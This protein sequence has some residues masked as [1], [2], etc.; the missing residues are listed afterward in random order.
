MANKTQQPITDDDVRGQFHRTVHMLHDR[1]AANDGEISEYDAILKDVEDRF[2]PLGM[3]LNDLLTLAPRKEGK[4]DKPAAANPAKATAAKPAAKAT[5]KPA[6][7]EAKQPSDDELLAIVGERK[8]INLD[9]L[10]EV[11]KGKGYTGD[12]AMFRGIMARMADFI[13]EKRVNLSEG[14]YSLAKKK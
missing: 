12:T 3:S 5:A 7:V 6:N 10:L 1:K 13:A 2:K 8:S 14:N 4:P 11:L 9:D